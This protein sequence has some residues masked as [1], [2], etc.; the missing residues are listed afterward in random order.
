[1]MLIQGG[2]TDE[3]ACAFCGIHRSQFYR[4]ISRGEQEATGIYRDFVLELEKARGLA[5]AFYIEQ[6][7]K[8]GKEDWK[9]W[10]MMLERRAPEQ[11][12]RSDRVQVNGHLKHDHTLIPPQSLP[13]RVRDPE[14][15]S[16]GRSIL[17][18][19]ARKENSGADE[20]VGPHVLPH[21]PPLLDRRP[22][23]PDQ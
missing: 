12:G 23:D 7:K 17:K 19:L 15:V 21:Q 1:M 20:S 18:R 8:T 11:F 3:S 2:H 4:W 9:F 14:S 13:D 10:M 6:A 16:D 22:S 5:V